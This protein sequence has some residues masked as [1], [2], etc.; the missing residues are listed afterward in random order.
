MVA[1]NRFPQL[2]VAISRRRILSLSAAYFD[3][4]LSLEKIANSDLSQQ[5][6][7]VVLQLMGLLPEPEK[8]YKQTLNRHYLGTLPSLA[9]WV[10]SP[11]PPQPPKF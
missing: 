4:I 3:D 8:S 9:S 11:K 10:S 1:F 5:G 6:T 2:R 7:R